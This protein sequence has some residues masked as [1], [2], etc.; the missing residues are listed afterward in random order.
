MYVDEPF[1]LDVENAAGRFAALLA[2]GADVAARRLPTVMTFVGLVAAEW[3]KLVTQVA[4]ALGKQAS[5][6]QNRH[7]GPC[8]AQPTPSTKRKDDARLR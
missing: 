1:E 4:R 8:R 5:G 3:R 2:A 7:D 6:A